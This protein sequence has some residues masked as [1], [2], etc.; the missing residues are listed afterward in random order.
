MVWRASMLL[1]DHL[2]KYMLQAYLVGCC[3]LLLMKSIMKHVKSKQIS[4]A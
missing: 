1:F 4:L 3:K 2:D